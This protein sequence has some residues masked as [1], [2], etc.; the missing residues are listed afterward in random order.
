VR[1]NSRLWLAVLGL[2]LAFG[3]WRL[4]EMRFAHGDIYPLYS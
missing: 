4:F 2:M 1:S 3:V